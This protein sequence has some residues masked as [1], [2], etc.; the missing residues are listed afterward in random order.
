MA[1]GSR[2]AGTPLLRKGT[3]MDYLYECAKE[4]VVLSAFMLIIMLDLW[5]AKEGVLWCIRK[6]RE[7]LRSK[8]TDTGTAATE[9]TE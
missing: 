5:W 9:K 4:T 3:D 7:K 6:I 8:E 2:P 1:R